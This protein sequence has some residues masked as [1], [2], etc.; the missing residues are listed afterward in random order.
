MTWSQY[1][2]TAEPGWDAVPASR[3]ELLALHEA[4]RAYV[5]SI[6][7]NECPPGAMEDPLSAS[8]EGALADAVPSREPVTIDLSADDLLTLALVAGI[9]TVPYR[10]G[11][12]L[13]PE[14][15]ALSAT[16]SPL[17]E[18]LLVLAE[19]IRRREGQARHQ[20][21]SLATAPETMSG[22]QQR[23]ETP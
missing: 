23:P 10:A 19:R 3:P 4:L 2:G 11:M 6:Q 20:T 8:I 18:R 5:S 17:A 15:T 12:L 16:L 21:L 9:M 13:S 22:A 7:E 14:E 1:D